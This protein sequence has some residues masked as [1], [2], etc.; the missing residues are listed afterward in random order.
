[1]DRNDKDDD[2]IKMVMEENGLR[3]VAQE[4]KG[5]KTLEGS[6]RYKLVAQFGIIRP[7]LTGGTR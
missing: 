3:R 1:M 2:S 5:R 4:K 7:E 6:G